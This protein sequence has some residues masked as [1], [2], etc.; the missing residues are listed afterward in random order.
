MVI[1]ACRAAICRLLLN[2]TTQPPPPPPTSN[3]STFY[4]FDNLYLSFCLSSNFT[5][6]TIGAA[7]HMLPPTLLLQH[8][9]THYLEVTVHVCGKFITYY[10]TDTPNLN[11]C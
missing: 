11:L 9:I 3:F 4:Q 7:K 6:S 1:S 2:V 10:Y 5:C 8:L